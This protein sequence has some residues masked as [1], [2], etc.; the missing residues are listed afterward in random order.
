MLDFQSNASPTRIQRSRWEQHHQV[1]LTVSLNFFLNRLNETYLVLFRNDRFDLQN[2]M[3]RQ[4]YWSTPWITNPCF[5]CGHCQQII[6]FNHWSISVSI[7]DIQITHLRWYVKKTN[8]KNPQR[9]QWYRRK[10]SKVRECSKCIR[11][12]LLTMAKLIYVTNIPLRLIFLSYLICGTFS[13]IHI[14]GKGT[15]FPYEVYKLWQPS[16]TVYRQSHVKLEMHY[17]GIGNVAA[18]E[19][20]YQNVDI[21]YAS[22]ETIITESEQSEHPDL[23]EFPV[24]AG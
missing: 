17:D 9:R 19:A 14:T 15:T 5:K 23:V 3:R 13:A 12:F 16:Y 11:N 22:I 1:T 24:M 8:R 7:F 21:E 4:N 10:I 6:L 20:L 2:K 18:K